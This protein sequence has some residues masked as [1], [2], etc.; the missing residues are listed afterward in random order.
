MMKVI[1]LD[2]KTKRELIS[3]R[4]SNIA[5]DMFAVYPIDDNGEL[6]KAS[7]DIAE[8]WSKSKR[9]DPLDSWHLEVLDLIIKARLERL[10]PSYERSKYVTKK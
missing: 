10:R 6:L 4:F 9:F 2:Q 7:I 1:K 8:I 5:F 3:K